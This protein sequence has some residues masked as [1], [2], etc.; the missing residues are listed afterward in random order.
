MEGQSAGGIQ[1]QLGGR[2]RRDAPAAGLV[3]EVQDVGIGQQAQRGLQG[4]PTAGG[5]AQTHLRIK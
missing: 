2:R 3:H 4:G 5:A 1:A